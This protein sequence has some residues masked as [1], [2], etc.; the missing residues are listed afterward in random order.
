M[1]TAAGSQAALDQTLDHSE[2]DELRDSRV[3]R[4]LVRQ[5]F[6]VS[7]RPLGDPH[8]RMGQTFGAQQIDGLGRHLGFREG[9][10]HLKKEAAAPS[11]APNGAVGAAVRS[12]Q[13]FQDFAQAGDQLRSDQ[14]P[15]LRKGLLQQGGG[16]PGDLLV[17]MDQAAPAKDIQH[18]ARF[19][20]RSGWIEQSLLP[21]SHFGL[22]VG[23][24]RGD[25]FGSG[26]DAGVDKLT[27]GGLAFD[28]G[29]RRRDR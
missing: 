7:R 28:A 9:Q 13:A 23:L 2:R 25:R 4:S 26:D 19:I 21:L 12:A 20:R 16:R 11:A 1:G 17:R 18:R 5:F 15:A 22:K 27:A 24:G 29:P 14:F 8:D 10:D 6:E 3:L